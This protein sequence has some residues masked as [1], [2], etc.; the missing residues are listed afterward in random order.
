MASVLLIE[1]DR[2]LAKNLSHFLDG[3]GHQIAWYVDPQEAIEQADQTAPDVIVLDIILTNQRS[4]IEFLYELRSYPDWRDLPVVIFSCVAA[5]QLKGC[6]E[7][8]QQLNI[9]AYHYKPTTT[10]QKLAH[11]I[12]QAVRQ[13]VQ[14]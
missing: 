13:P 10:L 12:N 7:S 14:A 3:L 9:S 4:G 11:T 1:T 6:L 2:L 8:M 5:E